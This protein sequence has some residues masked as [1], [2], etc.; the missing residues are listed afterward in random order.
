VPAVRSAR[1]DQGEVAIRRRQLTNEI[2]FKERHIESVRNEMNAELEFLRAKKSRA[3]NNLAGATWEQSISYEMSAVVSTYDMRI[4][5][6]RDDVA[7]L[8]AERD[9]L[10]Q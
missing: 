6:L 3:S 4:S 2:E 7:R 9:R 8:H 5:R 1:A 10:G